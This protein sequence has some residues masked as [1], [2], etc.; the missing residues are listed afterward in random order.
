MLPSLLAD[1]PIEREQI[2]QKL[3]Q[4]IYIICLFA[5]IYFLSISKDTSYEV[6][7]YLEDKGETACGALS[8]RAEKTIWFEN[9]VLF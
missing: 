8:R 3:F 4:C 2:S 7:I 5:Y 9:N 6:N 1:P